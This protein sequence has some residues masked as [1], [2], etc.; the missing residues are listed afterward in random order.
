[1]C[2]INTLKYLFFIG[3]HVGAH[4]EAD[5]KLRSSSLSILNIWDKPFWWNAGR[6]S[7]WSDQR[8]DQARGYRCC[9][10]CNIILLLLVTDR[11]MFYISFL[12]FL[13][14]APEVH[15]GLPF[16]SAIDVWG[17]GCILAFLY[18][19]EHLFPVNWDDE[20]VCQRPQT[21][22]HNQAGL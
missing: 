10:L 15:L 22:I 3:V 20:I 6:G 9:T 18:L 5:T 16:T 11:Q 1:M 19:A 2:C 8:S 12:S 13:P 17:V 4:Q 14:R 21:K 7:L